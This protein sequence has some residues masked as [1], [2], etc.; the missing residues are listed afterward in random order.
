MPLSANQVSV[1]L[2]CY[3][4]GPQLRAHLLDLLRFLDRRPGSHEVLVVEDGSRDGSL[5][6]LRE[7]ELV[8][9]ALRVLR[10]PRNMGKGFSIRNGVLNCRGRWIVV[11]DVDM[12][13]STG[14]L[15][16]VLDRLARGAPIVVGNRRLP[17]SVYT[18]NNRLVRY[19]YRRHR[20]GAAFNALVRLL[21]D[22]RTRDT[23]SGLKG[24]QRGVA[25][26][27]FDR[28]HADGFLFDVEIFIRAR[29]LGI[30]IEEIP[31]HLTYDTD[32][33]TVHQFREFF[34]IVPQLLRIKYL[35]LSHAYDPPEPLDPLAAP[36]DRS[37]IPS[38]IPAEVGHG[39]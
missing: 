33:S 13:Y 38:D 29:R 30:P 1:V 21:F 15:E 5:A 37:G 2:G 39:R 36:P 12:V 16:A 3:N 6:C 10:N 34:R 17:E 28:L 7:L 4:A 32:E 23:Q 25:F 35:E 20:L 31:V 9:P 24:F 11:T 14:N 27:I 8:H 26:R 22:V 18:V 19:V